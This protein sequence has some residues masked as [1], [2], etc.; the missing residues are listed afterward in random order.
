MYAAEVERVLHL[1]DEVAE[2]AVVGRPDDR[3]GEEVVA[4]VTREPGASVDAD[5]LTALCCEHLAR[6]KVP[7]DL[8]FV[9]E[10]PRNAM[11]KVTKA[12]LRQDL[13]DAN[14]R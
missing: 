5:A 13:A 2:A 8:H 14:V 3:L 7:V 12:V 9:D 6:Y 1:H 11:G 10:L 4:F